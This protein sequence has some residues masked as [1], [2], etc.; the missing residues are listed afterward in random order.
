ML[1]GKYDAGV[2]ADGLVR[3][4]VPALAAFARARDGRLGLERALH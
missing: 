2:R 4:A 3:A 1:S